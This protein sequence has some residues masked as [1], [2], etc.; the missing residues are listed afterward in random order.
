VN[1]RL[2]EL[3]EARCRCIRVES[4]PPDEADASGRCLNSPKGWSVN[5]IRAGGLRRR[6]RP[7]RTWISS[8]PNYQIN[9]AIDSK[10]DP[11]ALVAALAGTGKNIGVA[12]DLGGWLQNGVAPSGRRQSRRA[13]LMVLEASDRSANGRPK[14]PKRPARQRRRRTERGVPCRVS[15]RRE[16]ARPSRWH[17]RAPPTPT[18]RENLDAFERVML[19]AMAE[20]VRVMLA[21]PAGQI[22]RR[23]KRPADMPRQDRGGHTAPGARGTEEAAEAAGDGH[24]DVFGPRND[25]ARQLPAGTDGKRT[26]AFTP[27]SATTSK[28]LK[29]SPIKDFDA[30]FL[31]NI[32]GMVYNDPKCGRASALTSRKGGGMAAITP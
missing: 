27:P 19:P 13:Q 1:Y 21:S 28:L 32:C 3:N 2:R 5:P 6:R 7:R 4:L 8:L 25:S 29:V 26:G 22:V 24:P 14:G 18:C 17:R 16:A 31:N 15:R 12:A 23:D 11:K 10:A 20:R 9:I 30:V